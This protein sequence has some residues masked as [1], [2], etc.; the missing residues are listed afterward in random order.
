MKEGK[1]IISDMQSSDYKLEEGALILWSTPILRRK[2]KNYHKVNIKLKEIILDKA[3]QE[4][5]KS[6][7]NEGG[8]H[9]NEDL[10]TW[11]DNSVSILQSWVINAFQELTGFVA[12][13]EKYDGMVELNAWANVNSYGNYNNLHTHPGCV[14]SGVYY[15]NVGDPPNVDYPKSGAIEFIDPRVGSE[16]AITPGIPFGLQKSI[17]PEDGEIIIFP[18]WL[19]HWVHPYW[20]D[21]KRISIAFNIRIRKRK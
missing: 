2:Y 11:D 10:F 3:S 16:M 9:S 15:V 5:G 19:K 21:E 17:Q 8:W 6:K 12:K 14:W 4:N 20:G 13:G 18:S 7:S 1:S